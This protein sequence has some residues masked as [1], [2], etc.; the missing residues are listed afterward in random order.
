MNDA[1]TR[2]RI[3]FWR[4]A[5]VV[6]LLAA[7]GALAACGGSDGAAAGG[8]GG[9]S[10]VSGKKI[11]YV[12]TQNPTY[13]A[14]ACGAK[15]RAKGLGMEFG[16][17]NANVFT[18]SAQ[19]PVLNAAVAQRPD[20]IL[21]SPTDPNALRAPIGSA[22]KSIPVAT[23]LNTLNDPSSVTSQVVYNNEANGRE[24]AKFLA[25]RADGR[26]VKVATIA[27]SPGASVAADDEIKGFEEQIKKYPNIEYLGPEYAGTEDE[28]GDATA[29]T[30]ALLSAHPDLFGVFTYANLAANG[31]LTAKRQRDSDV[32]VVAG[33][34]GTDRE[35]VGALKSGQVA[36]IADF[37]FRESGAT[38]VDQLANKLSGKPVK[39]TVTLQPTLYTRDSFENP[40]LKGDLK[41]PNC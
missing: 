25:E 35:L 22:S 1:T 2:D 16:Q 7:S 3:H 34:S 28:T 30:N 32:L 39:K 21:I 40:K 29:R 14:I 11:T 20:A 33:Y 8:G 24:A 31:I 26:D 19:I 36:A 12:A 27:L 13:D 4:V 41:P 6:A 15:A 17:Q 5:A 10:G 23:I 37:P 9:D 38:A 18:A